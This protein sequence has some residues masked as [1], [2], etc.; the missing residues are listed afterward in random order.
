MAR[1]KKVISPSERIAQIDEEIATKTAEIK[2]LK[3][4]RKTQEKLMQSATM[5]EVLE[6]MKT[7]N[8]TMDEVK[9]FLE[10]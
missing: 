5:D 7:T 6:L 8:K 3:K 4:E 10:S 2:E 1:Q 9:Q